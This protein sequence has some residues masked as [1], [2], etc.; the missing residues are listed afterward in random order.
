MLICFGKGQQESETRHGPSYLLSSQTRLSGSQ[1]RR[2]LRLSWFFPLDDS[3]RW[4]QGRG[5]LRGQSSQ[6]T[7]A[8]SGAVWL[9]SRGGRVKG[10]CNWIRLCRIFSMSYMR[11]L[12]CVRVRNARMT[13]I[14]PV[15]R[16][17]RCPLDGIWDQKHAL[18]EEF[19]CEFSPKCSPCKQER[20]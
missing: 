13:C 7:T 6:K 11:P 20:A 2:L 17:G 10:L 16:R 19:R 9:G 15:P 18:P 8:G 14:N 1:V 3:W 12:M 4:R 5:L